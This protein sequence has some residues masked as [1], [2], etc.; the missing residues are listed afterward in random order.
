MKRIVILIS[1]R[2][3]NMRSIVEACHAEGW[4]AKV[5]AVLSNRPD[6]AGLAF[7][8]QHGIATAVVDHTAFA[9]REAFD[10]ALAQAIDAHAP[11]LVVLAGFMRI[12][13]PACVRRYEG[14]MLNIHP[15]LLPAF[16][17]LHTHR[18][19]IEAGCK[20][21]GATVHFVTAQ[22]DH[23][24]IVLQAKVPVLPSDDELILSE[25]VLA[26]EHVI[27][28]LAV[29]WFV[30]GQLRSERGVVTHTGGEPQL[31]S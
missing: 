22:L 12:L 20:V 9:T 21:A 15:S 7:A 31:H 4:P 1:G 10:T 25:R 18:R 26:K 16:P 6:A 28:P 3:S 13:G 11:E 23:G 30:E 14:R 19:A 27:Y 24:P 29:R 2:G 8:A 5:V 17:G